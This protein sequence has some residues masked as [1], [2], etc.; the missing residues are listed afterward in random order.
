MRNNSNVD[1]TLDLLKLYE[2]LR[3]KVD[4]CTEGTVR[5]FDYDNDG[6]ITFEDMQ[7][8]IKKYIDPHYFDNFKQIR[9]KKDRETQRASFLANKKITFKVIFFIN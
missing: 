9:E 3:T 1:K 5:K 4:M 2:F 6:I 7:N 8:I